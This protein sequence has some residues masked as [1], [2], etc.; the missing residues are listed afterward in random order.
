MFKN[1]IKIADFICKED[2]LCND[3]RY[4]RKDVPM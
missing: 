1:K 3:M 4:V 2:F